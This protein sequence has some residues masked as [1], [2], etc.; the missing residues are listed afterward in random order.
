[1]IAPD[2]AAI[3]L[4]L[5][6]LPRWLLWREVI[7][8][9][10]PTKQPFTAAGR[11]ASTTDPLTWTALKTVATVY[12]LPGIDPFNGIGIVLGPLDDG[13]RHLCGI[14]LDSCLDAIG[15]PHPWVGRILAV[16]PTYTEISPSGTGLKA[17]FL[18]SAAD[19]AAVLG[20]FDIE[21]SKWGS[22]RSVKG[23]GNGHAHGSAVEVYLGVGRYFTCTGRHWATAPEEVVPLDRMALE[24]LATVIDTI[25]IKKSPRGGQREG[26]DTSRSAEAFRFGARLIRDGATFEEMCE[27]IRTNPDTA[28]W[29]LE[30][31]ASNNRRELKR[32]WRHG[33]G[34]RPKIYIVPGKLDLMADQA[35]TALI[36]AGVEIYQRGGWLMRPAVT[37]LPAAD[38]GKTI[39]AILHP[40]GP[41]DMIDA[42][43]EVA[44]WLKHSE[45]HGWR[46][47]DPP[48]KVA[49]ILLG[50]VGKWHLPVIRGILTAPSIRP[51]GS[52]LT[53]PGYDSATGY[54]LQKPS[55]LMMPE[56]PE[57]PSRADAERS[58]EL[59][60][61][62]LEEFPFVDEAS[63]S[64][65]LATLITP[66][67]RAAFPVS[68]LHAA[69]A[70][71]PGSGKSYLMDTAA[72]ILAGDRCPI[73]AYGTSEEEFEKRLNGMLLRGVPLFSIDNVT[74]ELNSELL[75]QATERPVMDLRKLGKS[76][77]YPTLNAQTIGSAGNN[78]V[79]AGDMIR[80]VVKAMMDANMERPETRTFKGDP[81]ARV[82]A[83]RGK[84]IGAILTLV[85]AYLVR[86][87]DE[88]TVSPL[89]SYEGWSRFVRGPL[90]WLGRTD[91]ADTLTA[92]RDEDPV[93]LTMNAV[94]T[95]WETMIGLKVSVTATQAV[96]K[97]KDPPTRRY[98]TSISPEENDERDAQWEQERDKARAF[99]DALAPVASRRG[100][101]NAEQLGYWLRDHHKRIVQGKRFLRQRNTRTNTTEWTLAQ[102]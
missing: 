68:P 11:S 15:D 86:G 47:A 24:R 3:P 40:L 77:I 76:D 13:A 97:A 72:M 59:I 27:A 102:A 80:R 44:L 32:I 31:G 70:P 50:R 55:D 98:D 10:R 85:R 82:R 35:E 94:I 25:V 17:F 52:L 91:P 2:I 48:D 36:A 7:R 28:A 34:D 84:Y 87:E 99:R 29:Y 83:D 46:P 39:S 38:G 67:V 62:L 66:V 61:G 42:L 64:V 74:R 92:L 19:V 45:R 60:E 23:A 79:I 73:I 95:A 101:L 33:D 90:L 100:E 6:S 58:L 5:A 65:G 69:S 51:D 21:P 4:L 75:C 14:D 71:S 16:L 43:C 88:V 12:R 26:R 8:N 20:L 9:G 57:R 18:A 30:K 1:V 96:A 81:C 93:L 56:V 89:A 37:E 53:E 41:S 49:A 63:R 22:K 54:Y 78:M